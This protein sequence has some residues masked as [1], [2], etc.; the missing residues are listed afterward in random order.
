MDTIFKPRNSFDDNS[1][2]KLDDMSKRELIEFFE[3]KL[4]LK[5]MKIG[6][7]EMQIRGRQE[8]IA[9]LKKEMET[10]KEVL[11]EK[12]SESSLSNRP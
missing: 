1:D 5:Q 6:Q 12:D 2:S 8:K 11:A 4:A 10:L 9:K 3:Q 7:L